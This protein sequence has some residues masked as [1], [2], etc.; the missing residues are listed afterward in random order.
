M[1]DIHPDVQ[2]ALDMSRELRHRIADLRERIHGIRARLPSPRGYALAEVD[3]MSKL[4][5]LYLLNDATA[6]LS[7]RELAGEIMASIREGTAD[8]R[9]QY[10]NLMAGDGT[11][12][13]EPE[14]EMVTTLW[15]SPSAEGDGTVDD[16][17]EEES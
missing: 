13:D 3:A 9:Q 2:A 14:E 5:G 15:P 16:E 4:T 6:H 17:P 12:D 1:S 7:G 10:D 8:A 11:V